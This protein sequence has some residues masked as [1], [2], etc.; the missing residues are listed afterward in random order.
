MNLKQANIAEG[1]FIKTLLSEPLFDIEDIDIFDDITLRELLQ[2]QSF[3]I[4]VLELGLGLQACRSSL[5][6]RVMKLLAPRQQPVFK[7]SLLQPVSKNL[8]ELARKR[9]IDKLFWEL[10]YWKTPE[11]YDE[12]V[13]GEKL[14]PAIMESLKEDI[15]GK[16][17]LDAGAGS[18]RATFEC[19]KYRPAKVVAVERSPGLMKILNEKIAR[20]GA[21]SKVDTRRGS[22]HKIPLP[23]NSVDTSIS[24]SA[25]TA[26]PEQGGLTGLSELRRVTR[27]GG[28]IIIIWPRTEDLSWFKSRSFNYRSFSQMD[29]V[30]VTY[31]SW[32]SALRCAV[33]F[34]RHNTRLLNYLLE[35]Q[36]ANIPYRL[37]GFNPPRDYCWITVQA[38]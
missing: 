30:T 7:A 21:F 32:Q 4:N 2:T 13:E 10:T 31:R 34:Y 17:V 27:P 5:V 29:E 20:Q 25:F 36:T 8:V 19:F 15:N 6:D 3:E 22:F 28:K 12:L 35:F 18:G 26:L 33:R 37:L 9:V 1:H 11:L 16:V 24:C 23:D 14:H 38:T